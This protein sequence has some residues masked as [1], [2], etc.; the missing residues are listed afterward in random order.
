M[1]QEIK[2]SKANELYVEKLI[3]NVPFLAQFLQVTRQR[4]IS[5]ND[6]GFI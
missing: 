1:Q 4:I 2:K 6:K 3:K 5:R